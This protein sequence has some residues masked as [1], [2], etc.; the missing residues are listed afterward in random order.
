MKFKDV[1]ADCPRLFTVPMMF[2]KVGSKTMFPNSV[3]VLL[4]QMPEWSILVH[5]WL[6]TETTSTV[7]TFCSFQILFSCFTDTAGKPLSKCILLSTDLQYCRFYSYWSWHIQNE[8]IHLIVQNLSSCFITTHYVYIT[9]TNRLMLFRETPLF[10]LR[11]KRNNYT[12][13]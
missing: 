3:V 7:Y 9:K 11:I 8:D 2:L 5:A 6:P 12:V 10:F 4:K 13:R 1:K